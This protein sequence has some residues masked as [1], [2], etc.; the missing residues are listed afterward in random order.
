MYELDAS[1]IGLDE[2]NNKLLYASTP[3]P[4][5]LLAKAIGSSFFWAA[6]KGW[7]PWS[8][9]GR[10]TPQQPKK[11]SIF[12]TGALARCSRNLCFMCGREARWHYVTAVTNSPHAY[13]PISHRHEWTILSAARTFEATPVSRPFAPL[14]AIR[15]IWKQCVFGVCLFLSFDQKCDLHFT[16]IWRAERGEDECLHGSKVS[17]G[18]TPTTFGLV[19]SDLEILCLFPA[20]IGWLCGAML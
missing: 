5:A 17:Y 2:C 19:S 13:W 20:L 16:L 15:T 18:P 12:W 3:L 1:F 9:L 11:C 4:T 6:D 14:K 7:T 8:M 10:F